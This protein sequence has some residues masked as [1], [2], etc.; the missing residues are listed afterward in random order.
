MTVLHRG[1]GH[2]PFPAHLSAN[3]PNIGGA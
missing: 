1:V 2:Y 3:C